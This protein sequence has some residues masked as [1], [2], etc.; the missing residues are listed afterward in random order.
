MY[1]TECCIGTKKMTPDSM[2]D[3]ISASQDPTNPF[4]N[5]SDQLR[6]VA[7][8]CNSG[9]FDAAS[10]HLPL[11]ERQINGDATDQAILRFS[12][13]LGPVSYLRRC[14]K[15]HFEL[16]FNSKNKFMIRTL[17]LVQEEGLKLA[18][19]RSEASS[20]SSEDLQVTIL[21]RGQASVCF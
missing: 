17:S 18:L 12:E 13:F 16:A 20:W 14:W 10:F 4:I 11:Q 21:C 1:V 8:L 15:R 2:Q 9:E 19:P 5:A 6:A 7:G 3:E